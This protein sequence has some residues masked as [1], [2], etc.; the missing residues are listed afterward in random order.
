M[1][2]SDS[3]VLAPAP[4]W[5]RVLLQKCRVMG[6]EIILAPD[7]FVAGNK[8]LQFWLFRNLG[9]FFLIGS[10]GVYERDSGGLSG[11]VVG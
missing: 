5:R 10:S 2:Q 6:D 7:E 3:Q 1:R 4:P 11:A 9:V 8:S